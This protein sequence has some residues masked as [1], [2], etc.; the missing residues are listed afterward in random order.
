MVGESL[1][2]PQD[3][4]YQKLDVAEQGIISLYVDKKY[5]NSVE[6]R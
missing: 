3:E 5:S 6:F 4:Q 1:R 2:N